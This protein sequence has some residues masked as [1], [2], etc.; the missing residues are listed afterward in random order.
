[1]MLWCLIMVVCGVVGASY[2]PDQIH[3]FTK[4][5]FYC[6]LPFIHHFSHF[7]FRYREE[8]REMF[9]HAYNRFFSFSISISGF[10]PQTAYLFLIS[11]LEYAYPYDELRPLSCDGV[12][13]W[14]SYSL[15]LIG[16]CSTSK[17]NFHISFRC[18]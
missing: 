13:T 15:T 16:V 10:I 17:H 4:D 12:D 18:T 11:Y 3:R 6:L 9:Q 2:S 5:G 7:E 8:V 1:M 14:G